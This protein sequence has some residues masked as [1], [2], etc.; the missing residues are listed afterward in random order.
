MKYDK[1][2]AMGGLGIK[3][4]KKKIDGLFF[5]KTLTQ[6][7]THTHHTKDERVVGHFLVLKLMNLCVVV[8]FISPV[9]SR[10]KDFCRV[11]NK[12]YFG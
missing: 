10:L 2:G 1:Y 8:V 4:R 7:Y 6:L 3:R 5:K 11:S 12:K 9:K